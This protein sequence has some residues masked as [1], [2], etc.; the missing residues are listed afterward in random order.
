MGDGLED[1][2]I[3][4]PQLDRLEVPVLRIHLASRRGEH[5]VVRVEA[6]C[7]RHVTH[8]EGVKPLRLGLADQVGSG[9]RAGGNRLRV[10]ASAG[11]GQHHEKRGDH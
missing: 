11:G 8:H 9:L 4:T 5:E 7:R 6:S 10:I 3:Q 1:D 2:V